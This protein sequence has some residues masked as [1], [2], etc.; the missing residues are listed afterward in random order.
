MKKKELENIRKI[1]GSFDDY[2]I[3]QLRDPEMASEYINI[4]IEEGDVAYFLHALGNVVKAR[5]MTK[6]AKQAGINRE[7]AYKA[8]SKEGNPTIKNVSKVLRAVGLA[9]RTEPLKKRPTRPA[10]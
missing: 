4:A 5:G 2:L 8:V 7:N 10:A 1:T 3:E 6:V 9:L